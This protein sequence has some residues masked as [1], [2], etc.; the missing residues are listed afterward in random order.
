MMQ[1]S[2]STENRYAFAKYQ[3]AAIAKET[4]FL[5]HLLMKCQSAIIFATSSTKF[6]GAM[7]ISAKK[8]E[9]AALN[10]IASLSMNVTKGAMSVLTKYQKMLVSI[11]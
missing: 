7:L 11:C 5:R 9:M 8:N 2:F 3:G 6:I 4:D 10:Q 1:T